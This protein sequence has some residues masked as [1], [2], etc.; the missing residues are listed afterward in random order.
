MKEEE[1]ESLGG[2]FPC[3]ESIICLNRMDDDDVNMKFGR[4][5]HCLSYG[6]VDCL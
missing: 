4:L 5:N 1:R 3:L 2:L 6:F